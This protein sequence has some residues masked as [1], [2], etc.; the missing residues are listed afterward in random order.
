MREIKFKAWDRTWKRFDGDITLPLDR[1]SKNIDSERFELV[2]FTGI[3]DKNGK[4]IWEGDIVRVVD[5]MK[6]TGVF[7]VYYSSRYA[8]FELVGANSLG[9]YELRTLTTFEVIGNKYEN[10]EQLNNVLVGVSEQ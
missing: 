8:G 2:Q 7:E 6:N 10:P 3:K 4:E 9:W 1:M 5:N